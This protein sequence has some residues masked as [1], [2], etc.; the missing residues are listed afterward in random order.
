L[1]DELQIPR[2]QLLAFEQDWF[3]AA[4]D[5]LSQA[6]PEY[7]QAALDRKL[8]NAAQAYTT[9]MRMPMW[10]CGAVEGGLPNQSLSGPPLGF[11]LQPP[12]TVWG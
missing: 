8:H 2:D 1:A 4:C 9:I 10:L 6:D 11:V 3:Q 12:L 5:F 7:S